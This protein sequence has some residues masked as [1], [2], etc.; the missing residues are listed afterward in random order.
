VIAGQPPV[1]LRQAAASRAEQIRLGLQGTAVLYARAVAEEDWR[2]LGYKSVQAWAAAEFG[3]DRF[4]AERR[5]EV[6]AMLTDAGYTQRTIAAAVNAGQ[7]TVRR[8]QQAL[9]GEPPGSREGPKLTSPEHDSTGL[10]GPLPAANARQQAARD[11]EAARRERELRDQE[12]AQRALVLQEAG[13][14][15]EGGEWHPAVH[16]AAQARREEAVLDD[17]LDYLDDDEEDESLTPVAPQPRHVI[18]ARPAEGYVPA[19]MQAMQRGLAQG[20]FG[21]EA[22]LAGNSMVLSKCWG[23]AG[24][25]LRAQ[26]EE[27]ARAQAAAE[28]AQREREACQHVLAQWAPWED[29]LIAHVRES[30]VP[31]VV[32]ED[33]IRR[34]AELRRAL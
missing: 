3:F 15:T 11:R 17:D 5:R 24:E 29:R 30:G 10:T 26:Q 27:A 28:A 12:L 22:G 2:V 7:A 34:L 25:R 16:P 23:I 14:F 6:V 4:S 32:L 20:Q 19:A 13:R 33:L 9:A 31:A 21:A 18:P 8:D 1:A